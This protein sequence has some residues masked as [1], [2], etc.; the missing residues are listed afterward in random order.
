MSKTQ[1]CPPKKSQISRLGGVRNVGSRQTGSPS[2]Q[3]E[4][5]HEETSP[6]DGE[7]RRR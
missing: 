6:G 1:A 3:P 5:C 7:Q 4:K 2:I